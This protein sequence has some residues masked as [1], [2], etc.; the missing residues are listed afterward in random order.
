M[1]EERARQ[2][3]AAKR[4]AEEAAK[5]EKEGEQQSSSQDVTM[6][7]QDSVPASEADAKKT[8]KVCAICCISP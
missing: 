2:E 1:E 3:A 4:A 5:K 7:D 8:T 6:T